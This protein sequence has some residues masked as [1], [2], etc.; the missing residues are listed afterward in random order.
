MG[1]MMGG[2]MF[3]GANPMNEIAK[4]LGTDLPKLFDEL[5]AGKTI[6]DLAAAKSL[7]LDD[8]KAKVVAVHKENLDKAVKAGWFTQEQAD[9]RQA[10]ME[11]QV[12][13]MLKGQM[14]CFQGGPARTPS[15]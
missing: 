13:Y 5:R 10:W 8:V 4:A 9:Q 15:L 14:P 11:Q 12:D 2:M 6:A 7:N 1:G 3:G